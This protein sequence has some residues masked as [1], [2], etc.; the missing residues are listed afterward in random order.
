MDA[1]VTTNPVERRIFHI[2]RYQFAASKL[3]EIYGDT[4]KLFIVDAACGT[5]YGSDILKKLNPN[6][7]IGVDI[8]LKTVEYAQ[9]KYG[10]QDCIFNV[11]D[12][13]EMNVIKPRT[14]DAIVSFE[15]IEH[16][17]QPIAFLRNVKRVLKNK[18]YLIIS[19]PN[20]WGKT[21]DHRFDYDYQLLKTHL[22]QFFTI[23]SMYV[24]N[25]GSMDLWVNRGFP[26]RLIPL[27]SDNAEG[28][29]CFIAVARNDCGRSSD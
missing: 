6:K 2:D 20:N 7:I 29:E 3:K 5:G 1:N 8:C 22:S 18:G 15:T 16:L 25:S 24:Q 27:D 14:V 11:C 9:K 19:T 28:A 21:R 17:E 13:V 10:T 4:K 23:D 26:R 12:V